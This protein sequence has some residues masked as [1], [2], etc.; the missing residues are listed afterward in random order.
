VIKMSET[1][2]CTWSHSI[3]ETNKKGFNDSQSYRGV[4]QIVNYN[5]SSDAYCFTCKLLTLR[6][7]ILNYS[8]LEYKND[9]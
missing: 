8:R 2:K 9:I 5:K 1:Q 4:K 3:L 7:I 6:A